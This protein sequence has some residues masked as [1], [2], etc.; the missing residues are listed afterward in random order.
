MRIV[1][2][3]ATGH[4]GTG[5]VRALGADPQV[6]TIVKLARRPAEGVVTA[7]V[8]RDDLVPLFRG[9]DAVVHLAWLFQPTRRPEVTWRS[10]VEGS[11]RVLEA[12][13]LAGVPT[14]VVASSVGVYSPREGLDEVDETWRSH[15][16]PVAA[17]S[18]E[19]A[20]V[21]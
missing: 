9:A 17:Y 13:G 7:D 6:E 4:I 1:V 18:R 5:V 8:E 12:V 11:R 19:K 10:N 15:G 20:Y 21:E 2:T 16:V 14:V 3:G